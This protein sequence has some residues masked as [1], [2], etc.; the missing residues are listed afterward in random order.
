MAEL[1][2]R[3]MC[4]A[5][6]DR[7]ADARCD[8]CGNPMCNACRIE[9]LA[10]H[11]EY[12]SRDCADTAEADAVVRF[13]GGL[14][15]PF[16]TGLKLWWRSLAP[17]TRAV[18][19]VALVVAIVV[20]MAG[21]GAGS[22]DV[23]ETSSGLL[24]LAAVGLGIYGVLVAGTVLS[25][26]YTDL[27]Q[28]NAHTWALRRLGPWML[29]WA[30]TLVTTVIG[31]LLFLIPGIILALRLFWADEFSLVHRVGPW[32]AMK[33]SWTLTDGETGAVFTF[34]FLMGLFAW[35][36]FAVGYV[37][38]VISLAAAPRF[39]PLEVPFGLFMLS[40]LFFLAYAMLHG[41]EL[42]KF[43]GMRAVHLRGGTSAAPVSLGLQARH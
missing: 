15:S 30:C 37:L 38:A 6:A 18:G 35:L 34:Q 16:S 22:G 5:H 43:Y 26:Q 28:G 7:L 14:D 25:Q 32:R 41:V 1:M 19:P 3:E 39:G 21:L 33:E 42:V 20:W 17:L 9:A 36:V 10:A 40:L 27:V 4:V 29:T 11:E 8:H 23:A 12:C 2:S 31:Y 13:L 24:G